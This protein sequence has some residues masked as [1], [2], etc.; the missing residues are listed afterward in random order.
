[1]EKHLYNLKK[2]YD[3]DDTKYQGIRDV[4]NLFGEADEDYYEPIKTK[5]TFNGNY[6]EY[7]SKGDKDKNEL[8]EEYLDIIRPYLRDMI[9]DHKTRRE[10]KIQLTMQINFVFSKD[11]EETCTREW[12]IKLT[13][14]INFIFSKDSDEAGTVHTKCRNIEIMVGNERDEIIKKLFESLLRNYHKDLEES[15]RES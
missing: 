3:Y 14:Q 2:P 5:S 11:S 13:M 4:G 8:P 12:K 1:M 9:N 6:I 15:M 10:R 7:E